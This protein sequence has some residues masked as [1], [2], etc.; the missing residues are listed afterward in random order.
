[1][2]RGPTRILIAGNGGREHTLLWK[3]RRDAPEAAFFVTRPNG[4]MAG[5]CTAVDIAPGDAGALADW[6]AGERI[7]LAVVGPEGPL[8]AGLVDRLQARGVP[9]FGPSAAAARIESSKAFAKDLMAGAGVPT[10]GYEVH[11]E[12][13]RAAAC[14]ESWGAPVVVKASGLAA[15]KGAVVCMTV[16]EAVRTACEMLAGAFGEAGSRVVIEEFMEGEELSVF[17]IADGEEYVTLLPSQDHK[18]IGEGDTGPNTG[19]MGAYAPVGFVTDALMREVGDTVVAPVLRALGEAGCP[20]QGLL[21]AGLMITDEGPRVVEFNC[22]FGDPETQAVLPLLASSLLEPM[23]AVA[24][25]GGL[26]GHEPVFAGGAA[27][28]T[29]LA[30]SG[31]P[32]S[33]GKGAVVSIPGMGDGVHVFHAGTALEDGQLVTSGG[34]VMAVTAVAPDFGSACEASRGAAEAITFE[35]RYFRRDIGWREEERRKI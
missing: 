2:G 25:G 16:G 11:T 9:A 6:A 17:C 29:V 22:R 34:R 7:D 14:I 19:G 21:Y 18:R 35:G 26:A 27:V 33:Y 8:A 12:P 10:A 1:M 23:M 5:E 28:T 32:G 31:Y 3:L 24:G 30:A 20:F 15:G 13:D 4:G